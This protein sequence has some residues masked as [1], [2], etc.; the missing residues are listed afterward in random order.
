MLLLSIHPKYVDAIMA[1]EKTVELRRRKPSIESGLALIYATSPRKELVA[2]FEI[3]SVRRTPLVL[4]WQAVR[5]SAGVS[6]R[7]FYSYFAGQNTGV[8]IQ[9]RKVMAFHEPI[10]LDDLREMWR[11]F[12]PPQGFCYLTG[13]QTAKLRIGDMRMAA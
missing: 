9:I 5:D 6:R 8:A 3:S 1:G 12:Q 13:E 4:L 10:P 2:S 7:E 11:G